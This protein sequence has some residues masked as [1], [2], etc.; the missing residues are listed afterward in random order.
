MKLLSLMYDY[1]SHRIQKNSVFFALRKSYAYNE[2]EQ[3]ANQTWLW[4][5]D[6]IIINKMWKESVQL[7]AAS[8]PYHS[9]NND[10]DTPVNSKVYR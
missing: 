5:P 3:A 2:R 9:N 4:K 7:A 10:D 8:W 1:P 6:H